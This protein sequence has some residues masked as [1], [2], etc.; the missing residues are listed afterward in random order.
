MH[1]CLLFVSALDLVLRSPYALQGNS[2]PRFGN[3][4]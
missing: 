1:R 2:L 3:E 4:T